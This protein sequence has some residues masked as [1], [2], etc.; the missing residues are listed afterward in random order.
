MAKIQ[1]WKDEEVFKEAYHAM[2]DAQHFD[3]YQTE[4][5]TVAGKIKS[6]IASGARLEIDGKSIALISTVD[7]TERKA[8]QT[9]LEQALSQIQEL[10]DQLQAENVYLREEINLQSNFEDMVFSS[11]AL[12]RVLNEVEQVA[13]LDATVMITGETGTGKELIARAV[14]NLSPRKE[15]PMIKINCGALPYDLIESE[16]FGYEKGAFTGATTAKPGRF[17]LADQ[18]TLL[19]DEIGDMPFEVQVKLLRVIQEK[20]FERLGSTKTRK[21]DV[22]IVAAT[23]KNLKEEVAKGKFREDLYFRLN[24]FPIEVPALR[25]RL[26]DIPIL[27]EHFV[28]KYSNKHGKKV[29]F[30]SDEALHFFRSYDWP[31]NIRE[32]ENMIERSVILSQTEHLFVPEVGVTASPPR[33]ISETDKTL[34]DV[35]RAHIRQVLDYCDWKIEGDIGAAA[36]LGL[37]PSTL[38]DR[39]KKLG[40]SR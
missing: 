10:K 34:D 30:I 23:C 35:Q 2:R 25:K 20:E 22:R 3:N 27:V 4:I 36:K 24:V 26:D 37:K 5:E 21:V 13:P 11:E 8:A 32:L 19:L 14:H 15:R 16:L 28:N 17:E 7:I 31:G 1:F 18:G 6:V 40:V 38:R 39:M 12:G 29:K 9:Q 33:L